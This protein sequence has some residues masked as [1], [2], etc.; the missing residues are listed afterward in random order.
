[1]YVFSSARP[2]ATRFLSI[3][4]TPPSP[5][6]HDH[7]WSV[8]RG[9]FLGSR[10]DR[11]D[12]QMKLSQDQVFTTLTPPQPRALRVDVTV[13]SRIGGRDWKRAQGQGCPHAGFLDTEGLGESYLVATSL[14]S[15]TC[16]FLSAAL[17]MEQILLFAGGQ[18]SVCTA[19]RTGPR[20]TA[21]P[22]RADLH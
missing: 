13:Q 20:F 18:G 22:E 8:E 5:E 6:S 21:W 11:P 10:D 14:E 15:S 16:R 19:V 17:A 9:S 4:L 1:M 12:T 3:P 2:G 7:S